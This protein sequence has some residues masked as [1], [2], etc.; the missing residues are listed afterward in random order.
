MRGCVIVLAECPGGESSRTNT[1]GWIT[2]TTVRCQVL[3]WYSRKH[4]RVVRSTYA[5]ELLSVLD[6][7]GQVHN[8][9]T[10]F[11]EVACGAMAAAQQLMRR[12]KNLSV[13]KQDGVID[14][15]GVFDSVIA[16]PVQTPND[17][18]LLLH[19]LAFREHLFRTARLTISIGSTLGPCLRTG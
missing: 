7:V 5:A 3:D 16:D 14:A 9:T 12:S 1:F 4:S 10:C 8:L 11:D 17:K 18:Q 19:A 13:F 6:A 15:R 2:H